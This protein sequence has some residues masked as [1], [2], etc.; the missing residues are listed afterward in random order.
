MGWGGVGWG[1]HRTPPLCVYR[2][3]LRVVHVPC[4]EERHTDEAARVGGDHL[5][6]LGVGAAA[7]LEGA[8]CMGMG[9]GSIDRDD[10]LLPSCFKQLH[11][12]IHPPL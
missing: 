7:G 4:R 9:G 1:R 3:H 10:L 2:A 12:S 6:G 8:E 5:R 11:P